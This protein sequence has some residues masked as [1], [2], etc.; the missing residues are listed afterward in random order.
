MKSQKLI[1]KDPIQTDDIDILLILIDNNK[2]IPIKY[3]SKDLI[4]IK[5][6]IKCTK[7]NKMGQ[8]KLNNLHYCW[9]HAHS[10]I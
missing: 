9:I 2:P 3:Y 8:Y 10:L 6:K 5:Y 4:E 7:C 1:I